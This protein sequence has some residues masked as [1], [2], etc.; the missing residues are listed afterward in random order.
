[1][2]RGF[3]RGRHGSGPEPLPPWGGGGGAG[4]G[5]GFVACGGVGGGEAWAEL[6]W[7]GWGLVGAEPGRGLGRGG[8]R[9]SLG[10]RPGA[11]GSR[12]GVELGSGRGGTMVLCPV[13]GK[14][15]HKRVVLASASPRRQEILSNAVSVRGL[16]WAGVCR[17]GVW[18]GP[19]GPGASDQDLAGGGVVSA[20]PGPSNWECPVIGGQGL[21]AGDE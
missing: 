14:L 6:Q 21:V 9:L 18:G 4:P 8:R 5:W 12:R 3:V 11:C 15:Q 16:A 13:I 2:G 1:M 10:A 17:A 20:G 7:P 19:S